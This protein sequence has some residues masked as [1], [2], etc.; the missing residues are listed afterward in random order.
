MIVRAQDN[1]SKVALPALDVHKACGA[2]RTS[3]R[4]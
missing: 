3:V 1:I 2:A 4:A